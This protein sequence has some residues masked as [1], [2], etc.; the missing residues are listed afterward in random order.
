MYEKKRKMKMNT[1]FQDLFVLNIC[2]FLNPWMRRRCMS[3][4]TFMKSVLTNTTMLLDVQ[5]Y[6]THKGN[7]HL[8]CHHPAL[9]HHPN[10]TF[11]CNHICERCPEIRKN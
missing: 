11:L 9:F 7:K 2:E 3:V 6:K 10:D 8:P 1:F 5:Y 4:N